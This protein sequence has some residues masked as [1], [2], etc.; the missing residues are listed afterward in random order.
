MLISICSDGMSRRRAQ[1]LKEL[2]NKRAY[3]DKSEEK[4]TLED[5]N[6]SLESSYERR[7]RHSEEVDEGLPI[8]VGN[9]LQRVPRKKL[10]EDQTKT[11]KSKLEALI[12]EKQVEADVAPHERLM[13][14]K[15]EI[16]RH[17]TQLQD[18]PEEN[19]I[20]LTVL[21]RYADSEEFA[22]SMLA[23]GA[24]VPVFKS[25]APSYKIRELSEVEKKEKVSKEVARLR[26]FEEIFTKSYQSFLGRL[27]ILCRRYI[28]MTESKHEVLWGST[29][30]DASCELCE[31]SLKYF[32]FNSELFSIPIRVIGQKSKDPSF[33]ALHT[34]CI[35]T[36]ENLLKDDSDHGSISL[37]I[38]KLISL[39]VKKLNFRV[40]ESMLNILLSLSV[41]QDV[42]TFPASLGTGRSLKTKR[43]HLSKKE[44]K[45]LRDTKAIEEEMRRAEQATTAKE[46][47]Q[48]QSLIIQNILKLYLGILRNS[49]EN[50]NKARHLVGSVLEGLSKFGPMANVE[51]VGDF[52]V[53]LKEIMGTVFSEHSLVTSEWEI[54]KTGAKGLYQSDEI[55]IL[56]LCIATAF[57]LISN[58]TESGKL[59]FSVDLSYFVDYLYKI[60]A[61]VSLDPLLELSSKSLRLADPLEEAL[62]VKKVAVNVSTR[63]ELLLRCLDFV[64]FRS[65]NG[66]VTRSMLFMK[67]IYLLCLQTAE[68]TTNANLLFVK[69][70][71]HR[72]GD[73]L[74]SLWSTNDR[75]SSESYY[76]GYEHEFMEVCMERTSAYGATLWE[77]VLLDSH[78]SVTTRELTKSLMKKQ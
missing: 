2:Q 47:E 42:N 16:A 52:L 32:N 68:K 56:L 10:K 28:S 71:L 65:K 15:E 4:S 33:G 25:L 13:N 35:R 55:R 48:N 27:E 54:E 67:R 70:L 73:T 74:K 38:T 60:L 30:I 72:Y 59:P 50:G 51:L 44:R 7:K 57:A 63:S 53:V 40:D 11:P 39:K 8:K 23:I 21:C 76:L 6:E 77:N 1:L 45:A 31:S 43:V 46:R 34:K 49:T 66:S 5:T 12:Y 62:G 61:D 3:N 75:I 20:S 37:E 36:I 64:F 58:H 19:R 24:L 29:A 26:N 14:L 18:D 22:S 9:L 69:K 41:L 17:A 78:Y